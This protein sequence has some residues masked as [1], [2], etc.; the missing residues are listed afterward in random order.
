M[1]TFAIMWLK[2]LRLVWMGKNNHTKTTYSFK[3]HSQLVRET[4]ISNTEHKLL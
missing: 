2:E 3:V 1:F 4:T